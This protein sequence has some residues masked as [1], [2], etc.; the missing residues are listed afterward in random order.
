MKNLILFLTMFL[1]SASVFAQPN[2]KNIPPHSRPKTVVEP[3]PKTTYPPV[4]ATVAPCQ[5]TVADGPTINGVKLGL[6]PD[7]LGKT[8][9]IKITP[10]E[11]N[12]LE[13][14]S[15]LIGEKNKSAL[16]NG[17]KI[18]NLHFFNNRLYYAQIDIDNAVAKKTAAN[19]ALALS[20]KQHFSRA[21][22]RASYEQAA[23]VDTV[24]LFCPQ[25]LRFTVHLDSAF[26]L[27]QLEMLDLKTSGQITQKRNPTNGSKSQ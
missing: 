21:W 19:Y 12:K 9:K 2:P 18:I 17:I 20:D 14:S 6:T 11:P 10:G 15:F 1:L 25:E 13:V 22:F 7:E 16:P 8:F 24:Y 23:N 27:L 5:M 3:S 4:D 26:D